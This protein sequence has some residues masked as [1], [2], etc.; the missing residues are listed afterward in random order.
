MLFFDYYQYTDEITY[1]LKN[2]IENEIGQFL[3]MSLKLRY[4]FIVN[5]LLV[6]YLFLAMLS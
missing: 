2:D 6:C 1:L 4:R 3:Y 5:I